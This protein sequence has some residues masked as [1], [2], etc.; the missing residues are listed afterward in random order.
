MGFRV[1]ERVRDGLERL[2]SARCVSM[3][4]IVNEALEEYLDRIERKSARAE[5]NW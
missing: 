2:S 4:D 5:K 1:T 3:G